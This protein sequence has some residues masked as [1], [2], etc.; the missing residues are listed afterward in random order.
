MIPTKLHRRRTPGLQPD[1]VTRSRSKGDRIA[2]KDPRLRCGHPVI[3]DLPSAGPGRT[4]TKIVVVVEPVPRLVTR[5]LASEGLDEHVVGLARSDH[6]FGELV[7]V[8]RRTDPGSDADPALR[9]QP[10]V[11]PSHDADLADLDRPPRS[12]VRALEVIST[13]RHRPRPR[14]DRRRRHHDEQPDPTPQPTTTTPP[15]HARTPVRSSLR[16][17][18]HVPPEQENTCPP[19]LTRR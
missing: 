11:A 3:L 2:G 18:R 10:E 19:E 15:T 12:E 1:R 6:R 16:Q 8:H 13:R 9:R 7:P 5:P 14:G 4:V 17:P